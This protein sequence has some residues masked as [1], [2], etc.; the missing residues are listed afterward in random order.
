MKFRPLTFSPDPV[1]PEVCDISD[2]PVREPDT[3]AVE[4]VEAQKESPEAST[5]TSAEQTMEADSKA[6]E[7]TPD[8]D[9]KKEPIPTS[10]NDPSG[11]HE[12]ISDPPQVVKEAVKSVEESVSEPSVEGGQEEAIPRAAEASEDTAFQATN[13][14]PAP[15]TELAATD[16]AG[17]GKDKN[18]PEITENPEGHAAGGNGKS[19]RPDAVAAEQ[20]KVE[21]S[22]AGVGE[23][24][25]RTTEGAAQD[26]KSDGVPSDEALPITD[27][28]EEGAG[29]VSIVENATA[30]PEGKSTDDLA[31]VADPSVEVETTAKEP[32]AVQPGGDTAPEHADDMPI[33]AVEIVALKE[34][35][36]GGE[37]ESQVNE[38]AVPGTPQNET[39]IVDDPKAEGSPAMPSREKHR[40]RHSHSHRDGKHHSHHSNK[41]RESNASTAERPT[42]NGMA[43]LAAAK[44]AGSARKRRDSITEKDSNRDKIK[45]RDFETERL[46]GSSSRDREHRER[47]HRHRDRG[48]EKER[49]RRTLQE[50]EEDVERRKRHE[51][52]R[53]ERAERERIARAEEAA[54]IQAEEESRRRRRE[55]RLQEEE[56]ARRKRRE[57]RR[58]QRKAEEERLRLLEE[59]RIAKE[60]E[61]RRIRHEERRKRHEAEKEARRLE[62]EKAEQA[63][64]DEQE[65][66][67]LRRQR[68][69]ERDKQQRALATKEPEELER[70]RTRDATRRAAEEE[71][72]D[73]APP[74][75]VSPRAPTR[76]HTGER[77]REPPQ[78]S[79]RNS[80][81]GGIALF[82]RSRTEPA[83]P[84]SKPIKPVSRV[85]TEPIDDMKH[86]ERPISSHHSSNGSRERERHHRRHSHS[87][88]HRQFKSAEEE[89]EEYLARKEARRAA[90]AAKEQEMEMIGAND[91]GVPLA[92]PVEDSARLPPDPVEAEPEVNRP[93]SLFVD[94]AAAV[95]GIGSTSSGERRER[96]RTSRRI[97]IVENERPKSR[98]ISVTEKERPVSRR[99]ESD[100]P[101][102][103]SGEE[104]TRERPR[105]S[106]TERSSRNKKKDEGG[107]KGLFGGLK[108][109]MA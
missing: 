35:E 2:A 23:V 34:P 10:Q 55:E 39:A 3:P 59:E 62:R 69:A 46:K 83:V 43:L 74:T 100:R 61:A 13:G 29:D 70:P 53:A 98:R 60:E 88:H 78:Q 31:P 16:N 20:E 58:A 101:R 63:E 32:V 102:T 24:E 50:M 45:V 51:A 9:A 44:F 1:E 56:E 57:E 66:R 94:E 71:E 109:I 21:D 81:L 67:R 15:S 80:L 40:R 42:L 76:R 33:A 7:T 25:V 103:R 22:S 54:R 86:K 105:R 48:D 95:V 77:T 8:S 5:A 92:S 27:S 90:R 30:A 41:R 36:K 6:S 89:E 19:N 68:R 84:T 64:R 26:E 28:V 37:D 49:K 38:K 104:K 91:G 96:R 65:A 4:P 47:S 82:G 87:H 73:V 75:P 11:E 17:D 97:S 72:D 18:E 79:R 106:E 108:K 14:E 93:R 85:R 52:R 107:F 12:Q 99:S